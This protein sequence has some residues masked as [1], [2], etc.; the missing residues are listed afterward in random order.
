MIVASFYM[1]DMIPLLVF[2]GIVVGIWAVLSAISS[3]NSKALERLAK[4]SRPPSL[5]EIQD[6]KAAKNSERFQGLVDTAK[7]L[8]SPLMPQTDLEQSEL[9]T[10]LA[11]A[12]FR[13]DAA[14]MVYSGLRFGTLL[15][16]FA[17]SALIFLPGRAMTW[18]NLQW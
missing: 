5:A 13:S 3:R 12:G 7:A 16:F 4:L 14:P 9:K 1:A 10:K 6:P 17:T 8:S 18:S 11:N 15:L 2:L